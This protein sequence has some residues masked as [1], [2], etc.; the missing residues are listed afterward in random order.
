[1]R[2]GSA[3]TLLTAALLFHVEDAQAVV[4]FKE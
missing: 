4:R 2:P 1:M 3:M